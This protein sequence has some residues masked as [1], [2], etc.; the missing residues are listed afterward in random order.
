MRDGA[1]TTVLDNM[2]L[3]GLALDRLCFRIP[4]ACGGTPST[5]AR[6]FFETSSNRGEERLYRLASGKEDQ[7][8][9]YRDRADDYEICGARL[10]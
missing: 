8:P 7:A 10:G 1:L 5:M 9:K 2:N 4:W 6:Y 3:Q